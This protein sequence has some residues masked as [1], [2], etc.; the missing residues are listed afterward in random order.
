MSL[1]R[2]LR[3]FGVL[4]AM[5]AAMALPPSAGAT[6][7]T[8]IDAFT[9]VRSGLTNSALG[10]YEGQPVFYR[11]GFADG[12][13]PPSGGSFFNGTAGTYVVLGSYP[14]G[15]EG[16]GQLA[17]NSALGG[18]FVNANA[19]GRTVQRSVLPTDANPTSPNG[20]KQG[21]HTFAAF[22]LFDLTIPPLIGDGY[23]IVF[24]DSGPAGTT[25][26]LE[27]FVR[28]DE[29]GNV[30][31][32]FQEEDFLNGQV[33][34]IE[35][36]LLAAPQG[37]DQIE[38]RLQRASLDTN[39]VTA[40]YRFHDGGLTGDWVEMSNAVDF[41]KNNGWARAGFFA[42]EALRVPEPGSL[43]LLLAAG[44]GLAASRRRRS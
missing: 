12:A 5:A 20:L 30:Y 27:L 4:A 36:D 25:T 23:G 24:N 29:N 14:G 35:R 33:H 42:V 6:V 16:G 40:A 11:D 41:F 44:A 9:I 17:M 3:A 8:A 32:R 13:E 38:L 28:R 37:V 18:P 22:G 31:I 34:T 39:A 15:A 43:A 19:V 1:S 7:V 21:L 2:S 10:S 26:S